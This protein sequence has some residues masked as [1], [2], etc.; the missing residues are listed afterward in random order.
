M[1]PPQ[2]AS[3]REVGFLT[4]MEALIFKK[5]WK[6]GV[7]VRSWVGLGLGWVGLGAGL[8]NMRDPGI[9]DPRHFFSPGTFTRFTRFLHDLRDFYMILHDFTRFLRNFT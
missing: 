8:D 6:K 3:A 2:Q 4:F 9:L 1:Q 5:N 7:I